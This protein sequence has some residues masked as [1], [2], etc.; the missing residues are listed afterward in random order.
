MCRGELVCDLKAGVPSPYDEHRAVGNGPAVLAAVDLV[1]VGREVPCDPRNAWCLERPGGDHDL[2]GF[3][4]EVVGLDEAAVVERP[5]GPHMAV[6]LD[7]QLEVACVRR[8]VGDDLVASR[9]M[10]GV[11]RERPPGK[12]VVAGWSE[13]FQRVPA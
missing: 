6:E 12:A 13:Q 2:V 9:V 3:I 10:G 4:E 5:N 7:G 11:A 8:Q 1:D